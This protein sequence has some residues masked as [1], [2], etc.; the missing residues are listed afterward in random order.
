MIFVTGGT[1]LLGANLLCKLTQNN[2][3]ITALKCPKSSL[4]H[5]KQVFEDF[6]NPN[7]NQIKWVNGDILDYQLLLDLI[8]DIKYIYHTAAFVS[9]A[10]HD[11]KK[12][13]EIN[14]QGTK[15]MV[16]AALQN[17]IEKFCHVSSIAT[18]ENTHQNT[19]IDE[20]ALNIT[21]RKQSTYSLTKIQSELEVWRAINE[22]L[23][24]VIVNPSVI[25][26]TAKR[27]D[28]SAAFFDTVWNGL[29]FYTHGKTG[30][31]DVRDVVNLMIKLTNS[32]IIGERFILSSENET[33]KNIFDKI[34]ENLQVKPPKIYATPI[35][36]SIAWRLEAI[37]AFIL[38]KKPLITKETTQAAHSITEYSTKKIREKFDNYQF[39]PL[40]ETIR[41]YTSL[42]LKNKKIKC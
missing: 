5:I 26:T 25:L 7:F 39:I 41:F 22:G 6:D 9:F 27:Q 13:I 19:I 24:A 21:T 2:E 12:M 1:G 10:P 14:V 8:K 33:Y 32:E 16:N 18:L 42:F 11:K 36:T 3:Q 20:N 28:G 38:Q 31:V 4:E 34:A 30:F 35:L 17:N 23:K 40:D 29:K 37:K 15:N